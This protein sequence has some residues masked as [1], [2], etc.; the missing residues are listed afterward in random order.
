[1]G[2]GSLIGN[3]HRVACSSSLLQQREEVPD[4]RGMLEVVQRDVAIDAVLVQ[5]PRHD[6]PPRIVD[7]NI[8]PLRLVHDRLRHLRHLLPLA[9]IALQPSNLL[10]SFLAHLLPD[11]IDAVLRFVLAARE[12]E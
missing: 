7:E 8:Q 1:M 4:Q 10:G 12:D 9:Q 5:R 2:V 11:P 3:P 6:P